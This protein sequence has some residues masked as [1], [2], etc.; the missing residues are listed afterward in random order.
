MGQG[1][2][3]PEMAIYHASEFTERDIDMEAAVVVDP[4]QQASPSGAQAIVR[5]LPAADVAS[6][7]HRCSPWEIP[8]VISA[9]Y[10]WIGEN[11][12]SAAGPY[13]EIHP[14][15]R[16]NDLASKPG[17]LDSIVVEMQLPVAKS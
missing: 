13:R 15:W 3:G 2:I 14:Y 7:V 4:P 10:A 11:G 12:Y 1:S 5:E 8:D 6:V 17:G 9:L 16:E